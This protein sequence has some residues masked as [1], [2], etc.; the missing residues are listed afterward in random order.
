MPNYMNIIVCIKQV[1]DP[2]APPQTFQ[3]DSSTNKA[4]MRGASP[5]IDPYGEYAVEAALKI[6]DSSDAK[7]TIITMGNNLLREVVKKPLA[8]GA[9]VL[10]LLDVYAAGEAPIPGA[11][12]RAL[13][14]TIRSRSRLEPIFVAKPEDAPAVLADILEDGDLVLTQGAGNVGALAR[15]LGEMK[16]NIETMKGQG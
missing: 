6:K 8:M 9:D 13:C 14:R 1:I 4:E 16:L 3:I 15:K 10:V 7:I 2:E 12:G 11:D 5:V